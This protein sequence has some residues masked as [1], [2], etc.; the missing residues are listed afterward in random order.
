MVIRLF[1][2]KVFL[3]GPFMASISFLEGI[4]SFIL[5]LFSVNFFLK[6]LMIPDSS[7]TCHDPDT[8][9]R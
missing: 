2:L 9:D 6:I 4:D 5:S 8:L 3:A 1:F 7:F